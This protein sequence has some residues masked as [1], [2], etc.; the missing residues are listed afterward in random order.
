MGFYFGVG[1][2]VGFRVGFR[3]GQFRIIL[4][5]LWAILDLGYRYEQILSNNLQGLLAQAFG[6]LGRT[7]PLFGTTTFFG[8]GLL[9]GKSRCICAT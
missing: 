1:F 4:G 5:Q 2:G 6:G 7:A 9:A 8:G 3:V